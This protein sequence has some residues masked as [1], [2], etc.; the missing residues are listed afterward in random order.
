MKSLSTF[1]ILLFSMMLPATVCLGQQKNKPKEKPPSQKEMQ[2]MMKQAQDMMDEAMK[3]MSPEE[4][5][6]MQDALKQVKEMQ[7]SG[8][9]PT[10]ASDVTTKVPAIQTD[11]LSKISRFTSEEQ[12]QTYLVSMK[13]KAIKTIPQEI[14]HEVEALIEKYKGNATALNNLPPALY[15]RKNPKA[16]VYA[17]IRIAIINKNILLSQNNLVV[18]LHQ[19]G[20]PQYAISIVEYLLLK[21]KN[22]A[23]YNNAGQNY[24]SL[25]DKKKAEEYFMAALTIDP[26]HAEANSG[27]AV[28]A[29]DNGNTAK[30]IPLIEKAMKS[31]YSVVLDKLTEQKKITLDFDKLK[32]KVPEYFNTNNYK[33]VPAATNLTEVKSVLAQ[34][35]QMHA[36]VAVWQRKAEK[37]NQ[38]QNNKAEQENLSQISARIYG[39]FPTAPFGKKAKFMILQN[40][41]AMYHYAAASA[42]DNYKNG[43]EADAMHDA[44]EER[45]TQRHAAEQPDPGYES[46][47]IDAEETEKFLQASSEFYDGVVRKSLF[48]Y[49]DFANQQLHWYRFLLNEEQYRTV[50]YNVAE[51]LMQKMESYHQN[52]RLGRPDYVVTHCEKILQNPP[53]PQMAVANPDAD[54][55]VKIKIPFIVGSIKAD[56]KGWEIEGGEGVV[57]G[58]QKEYKSGE[59]TIGMGLGANLELPNTIGGGGKGQM[60]VKLDGDFSPI[61]IGMVLEASGDATLGPVMIAEEKLTATIGMTSGIHLDGVH[62]GKQTNIFEYTPGK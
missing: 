39:F 26:A 4:K 41:K 45:I 2:D 49:Y 40:A 16:A 23:L 60:F 1:L 18:L 31:G 20:Y 38:D 24:L 50:F 52:Q 14:R 12:Y 46:C 33:P 36:L 56:C 32:C 37:E 47:K 6:T 61:D 11:L 15:L 44:L 48:K 57:L 55:P 58:V 35:D 27:M 28:I 51:D 29:V 19:T 22:A 7:A 62:G 8:S 13:S 43:K 17:A 30:A 25:G 5:K 9:L 53:K 34:R 21:N 3:D 54:C 10:A 42:M 59:I